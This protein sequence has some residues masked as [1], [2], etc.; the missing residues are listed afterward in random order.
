MATA[1]IKVR[2]DN[3]AFEEAEAEELG[4]ILLKLGHE[5]VDGRQHLPMIHPETRVLLR[6][7]NGNR[8]GHLRVEP[9]ED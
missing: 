7:S 3:A 2:M 1:L 9:S 8:V 4:R 6:D 5:L